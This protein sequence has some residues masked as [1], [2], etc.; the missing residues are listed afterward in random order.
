MLLTVVLPINI[1]SDPF[2]TLEAQLCKAMLFF[3]M[4]HST[5]EDMI[6]SIGYWDSASTQ[7]AMMTRIRVAGF[8]IGLRTIP[9]INY[10]LFLGNDHSLAVDWGDKLPSDSLGIV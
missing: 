6:P 10:T 7:L 2:V 8:L 3:K 1:I 4:H 9:L 5:L